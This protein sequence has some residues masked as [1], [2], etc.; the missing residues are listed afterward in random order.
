MSKF[1]DTQFSISGI[2]NFDIG[3]SYVQY[4]LVDF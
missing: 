1:L 2:A 3:D 4:N